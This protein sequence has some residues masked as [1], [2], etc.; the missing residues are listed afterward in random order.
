MVRPTRRDQKTNAME[1]IG[2]DSQISRG[3]GHHTRQ[4]WLPREAPGSVKGRG[5][6]KFGQEFFVCLFLLWFL[7]E[8]TD[9]AG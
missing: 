7:Q 9:K 5:V 1:K 2:C 8:E 3:R 4:G 6:R